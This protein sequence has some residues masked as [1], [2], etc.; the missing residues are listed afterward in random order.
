M[1]ATI[2][3]FRRRPNDESADWAR[4]LTANL[5]DGS[6]PTG[7]CVFGALDGTGGSAF[8]LWTTEQDASV[9]AGRRVEG[10]HWLDARAYRVAHNRAGVA[11][12]EEPR[13][14]QLVWF[15]D[16]D[17]ERADGRDRAGRE[18]I[19]PAVRDVAGVVGFYALRADDGSS[20]VV[21][22]STSAGTP[23]AVQ[24]AIFSTTL[25]PW[26]NPEHLTGPSRAESD[27]VLFAQLPAEV[28]S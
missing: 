17:Q 4:A 11:A 8:A 3:R 26:E 27:R 2:H 16:D 6:T 28:R 13:F 20:V 12:G 25:L 24:R 21:G 19:W 14:A 5:Y 10:E 18:R 7:V 23:D 15:D 9:A 1:Y 22:L